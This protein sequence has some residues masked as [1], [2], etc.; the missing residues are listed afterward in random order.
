MNF[1]AHF[2]LAEGSPETLAGNFLGDF[3][4][5]PITDSDFSPGIAQGIRTHRAVDAFADRHPA[6]SIS[7]QRFSVRYRRI[8]GIIVD[9]AYDHFLSR[10]W[11]T[12][13]QHEIS[14]FIDSSYAAVELHSHLM[15]QHLAD[16]IPTMREQNWLEETRTLN[17]LERIFYRM[18]HR[19]PILNTIREARDEVEQNFDALESDFLRFFPELVAHV[20]E[21]RRMSTHSGDGRGRSAPA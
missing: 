12:F 11:P 8:S 21:R 20:Q 6:T 9:I 15:P 3:I 13:S 7:R 17:G 16:I 19:S 1:L 14:A 4:K 18:S 5:G 2:F 10:H